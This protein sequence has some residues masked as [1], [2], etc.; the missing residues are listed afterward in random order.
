MEESEYWLWADKNVGYRIKQIINN[1]YLKTNL[2]MR[3]LLIFIQILLLNVKN[4]F[5]LKLFTQLHIPS[6]PKHS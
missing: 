5:V 3:F 4:V 6:F 2:N 1:R